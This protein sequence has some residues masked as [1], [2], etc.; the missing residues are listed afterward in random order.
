MMDEIYFKMARERRLHL[1]QIHQ[2]QKEVE[3]LTARLDCYGTEQSTIPPI[4]MTIQV[5]EWMDEY[6]MPWEV[7]FCYDHRCWVDELD[8]SFPY[9]LDNTCPGCR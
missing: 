2:L 7:F 4:Q 8:N 5:R 1:Q 3:E 6:G 9:Y